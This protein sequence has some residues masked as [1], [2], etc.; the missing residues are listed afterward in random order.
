MRVRSIVTGRVYDNEEV[1]WISNIAQVAFY[2]TNNAII[3]D[4]NVQ[5][6]RLAMAFM[7]DETRELYQE[8]NK[9]LSNTCQENE[10]NM[11]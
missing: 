11:E 8:W 2:Y 4:V 10:A 1:I 7:K 6:N 3:Y 5:K 9:R